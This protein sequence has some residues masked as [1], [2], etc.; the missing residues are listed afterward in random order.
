MIYIT[1]MYIKEMGA[2]GE[3]I[4]FV[5]DIDMSADN[6]FVNKWS[7]YRYFSIKEAPTDLWQRFYLFIFSLSLQWLKKLS[8]CLVPL[9]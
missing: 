7:T 1:H 3:G 8:P 4:K 6:V 2:T 5:E 9:D